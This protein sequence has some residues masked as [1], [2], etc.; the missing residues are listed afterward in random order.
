MEVDE[1]TE[2]GELRTKEFEN[3]GDEVSDA[4]LDHIFK[5]I[6]KMLTSQDLKSKLVASRRL[7]EFSHLVETERNYVTILQNILKVL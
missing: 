2:N 5:R 1:D 6:E 4:Q 7:Q 3:A